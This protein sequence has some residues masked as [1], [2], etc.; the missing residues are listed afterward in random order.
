MQHELVT[1]A[2]A[3]GIGKSTVALS[4]ASQMLERFFWRVAFVD[5]VSVNDAIAVPERVTEALWG[6]EGSGPVLLIMDNCEHLVDAVASVTQDII[7]ESTHLRILATSREPLGVRGE[8]VCRLPPLD[9]PLEAAGLTAEEALG[10]PAIEL[11]VERAVAGS[12]Y[13]ASDKDVLLL[14][15][16]CRRVEGNPLAIELA[17]ARMDSLGLHGLIALMDHPD[18]IL[19]LGRRTG[20]VRHRTLAAAMEW[21]YQLL[22]ECEQALLRRLSAF[23]TGFGLDAAIRA[24]EVTLNPRDV[25]KALAGLVAKS[26]VLLDVDAGGARQPPPPPP[27]TPHIGAS[28]WRLSRWACTV[29]PAIPSAITSRILFDAIRAAQRTKFLKTRG[30]VHV[31]LADDSITI[32]DNGLGRSFRPSQEHPHIHWGIK[33]G[34][35]PRRWLSW[36]RTPC[37]NG[38]LR[39]AHLPHNLS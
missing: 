34:P 37:R 35:R 23:M 8:Q 32:L 26:L 33:E 31:T 4:V 19:N 20:P 29:S 18:S 14:S 28:H 9:A 16:L 39:R 1:L 17:A 21:S 24:C 25:V 2:G 30:V 10:Y 22:S 5:L 13:R 27:R 36:D 7:L 38:V 3:G 6:C 11:F 15:E 12:A